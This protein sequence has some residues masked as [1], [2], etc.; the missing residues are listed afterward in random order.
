MGRNGS[1]LSQI[2]DDLEKKSSIK[3]FSERALENMFGDCI[4]Y[5]KCVKLSSPSTV[6]RISFEVY[7][8]VVIR[9]HGLHHMI[10]T[11]KGWENLGIPDIF[12]LKELRL[13]F[14]KKNNWNL[15]LF[16]TWLF[17]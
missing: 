11:V 4:C 6:T 3:D 10:E 13:L 7:R 9:G 14:I 8:R 12:F 17:L 16:K 2:R 15:L 5:Y 1:K